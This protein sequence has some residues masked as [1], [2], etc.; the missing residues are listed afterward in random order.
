MQNTWN[1]FLKNYKLRPAIDDEVLANL[2]YLGLLKIAGP[3]AKKFLQGQLTCDLEEITPTQSRLGAHCNPQG[4]IISLFRIFFL[5]DAYYLQM[6]RTHIPTAIKNLK[7]YAVF[8]KTTLIDASHEMICIGYKGT[9]LTNAPTIDAVQTSND[10]I[11]IR[12]PDAKPRFIILGQFSAISALWTLLAT[13]AAFISADDWR[14]YDIANKT[15]F[16]YPETTEKFLPHEL[17]LPELNGVNFKKG[18]YTGQ[19]IIAR[20]H[21]RGKLKN[22]LFHATLE[23]EIGPQRGADIYDTKG[24]AGSI[25]DYCKKGYNSYDLLIIAPEAERLF[26]D[27][28]NKYQLQFR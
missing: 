4:R 14:C 11:T 8:F 12:L 19:E 1:D 10:L 6:P 25:V 7:K 23:A 13:R 18:C 9:H 22:Q 28:E 24:A 26:L 3:D 15:T 21:Y 2:D 27:L 5:Q 20:M 17:Q 16:I